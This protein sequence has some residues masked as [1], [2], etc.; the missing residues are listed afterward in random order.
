MILG[1]T[2]SLIIGFFTMEQ[3]GRVGIIWLSALLVF[4]LLFGAMLSCFNWI[5]IWLGLFPG[6]TALCFIYIGLAI[7]DIWI[8]FLDTEIFLMVIRLGG[9]FIAEF[10]KGS[11]ARSLAVINRG[12]NSLF[13]VFSLRRLVF[14]S[15]RLPP[16]FSPAYTFLNSPLGLSSFFTSS[17]LPISYY[18]PYVLFNDDSLL[19]SLF[20]SNF[21]FGGVFIADD[22]I[23]GLLIVLLACGVRMASLS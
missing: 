17:F 11:K 18:F 9:Y 2:Y 5:L 22:S 3:L 8:G 14:V 12:V 6:V 21:S 1:G 23:L 4:K 15:L 19:S 16:K 20:S 13:G 7:I 10:D